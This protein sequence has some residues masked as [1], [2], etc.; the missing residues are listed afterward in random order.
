MNFA[1]K[2][3]GPERGAMKNLQTRLGECLF[4]SSERI[5]QH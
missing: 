4:A 2:A 1:R 5:Q 3:R